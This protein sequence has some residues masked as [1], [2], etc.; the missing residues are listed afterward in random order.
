MIDLSSAFWNP[1]HNKCDTPPFALPYPANYRIG[2]SVGLASDM[3]LVEQFGQN[4]SAQ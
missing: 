2:S 3:Q 4:Y 1:S